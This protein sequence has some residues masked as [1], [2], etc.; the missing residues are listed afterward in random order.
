MMAQIVSLNQ[1]KRKMPLPKPRPG[2]ALWPIRQLMPTGP[3]SWLKEIVSG[4]PYE[5][6]ALSLW[7]HHPNLRRATEKLAN[8]LTPMW[9][10]HQGQSLWSTS[11]EK[12]LQR[13]EQAMARG[14]GFEARI[15]GIYIYWLSQCAQDI[16]C[17]E[18]Y[19]VTPNGDRMR[20]QYFE[21][22]L[23]SWAK[24][25]GVTHLE[26]ELV[27]E[28]PTQEVVA[29]LRTHLIAHITDPVDAGYV[30]MYAPRG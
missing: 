17:L 3:K 5:A 24:R 23:N 1:Y 25:Y 18:I 14:E 26:A 19:G 20:W 29:G 7:Q 9:P 2:V 22:P 16:A 11:V 21:E 4:K 8:Y 12:A 10:N 30:E 15:V 13:V 6:T 28:P 27:P